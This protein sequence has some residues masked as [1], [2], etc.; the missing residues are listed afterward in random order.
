MFKGSV[1]R[2]NTSLIY[3]DNKPYFI[4]NFDQLNNYSGL[5]LL[6]FIAISKKYQIDLSSNLKQFISESVPKFTKT[7]NL[8]SI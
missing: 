1:F 6:I 5:I 4:V 2:G 8:K 7:S 3:C